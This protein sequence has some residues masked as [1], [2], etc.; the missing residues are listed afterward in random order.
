M[1]DR[2]TDCGIE[3]CPAI[4]EGKVIEADESTS[5]GA[6]APLPFSATTCVPASSITVSV[7]VAGSAL[8][9]LNVIERAQAL[10][11]A[12]ELPHGFAARL[13]GGDTVTFVRA[14]ATF[15]AF[16]SVTDNELETAPTC[17]WPKSRLPGEAVTRSKPI[18]YLT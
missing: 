9:G 13:N 17:T 8:L 7:P 14:T 6:A 18:P 3:T 15:S 10:F 12:R 16:S 11:A 4:V 1:F 2:V 5:V